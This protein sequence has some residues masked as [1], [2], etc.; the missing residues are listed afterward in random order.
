MALNVG[1]RWSDY[2]SFDQNT[3][4]Q[5]GLRWQPAEELTLRANYAEVFRAPSLVEL[6]E[7]RRVCRGLFRLRSV[8]K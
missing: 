1:L 4:W 2:S 6:Y 7:R 3:S 5:A 8:R